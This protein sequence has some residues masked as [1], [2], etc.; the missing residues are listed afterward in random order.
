IGHLLPLLER[1]GGTRH[2]A[3][4]EGKGNGGDGDAGEQQRR[5]HLVRGQAGRLHRDHFAVLIEL[6]Q[7][8]DRAE[9]HRI[10]QEGGSDLRHA[11]ADIPPDLGIAI[12]GIG[13]D[14][15]AFRQQVE[16]LEDQ[17]QRAENGE[18]ARQE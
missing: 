5:Q 4:V 18:G 2:D 17:H 8:Q 1:R 6:G 9:Q 12:A 10:G 13:Q 3:I 14:R 7:R 16:R 15:T 11:Q